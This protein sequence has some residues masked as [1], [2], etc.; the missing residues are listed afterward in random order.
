MQPQP[1]SRWHDFVRTGDDALLE[2]LLDDNCVFQSPAVHQPQEGRAISAKYLKAAMTVLNNP[3]FRY[4]DEW[5]AERSAVLEFEVTVDG[6]H[7]NGIDLIRWN[8]AG[9]IENFKVMIRPL[10]AL[11][12]VVELMGRELQRTEE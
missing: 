6:L 4:V 9:R 11:N 12:H 3:T 8:E 5:F 1:I 10:K 2:S 7:V